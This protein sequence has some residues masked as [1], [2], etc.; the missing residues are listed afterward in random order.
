[1]P[2]IASERHLSQKVLY[3]KCRRAIES[4][5]LVWY[6]FVN[7]LRGFGNWCHLHVWNMLWQ[8]L[9]WKSCPSWTLSRK[10]LNHHQSQWRDPE[11]E[12]LSNRQGNHWHYVLVVEVIGTH[13]GL[14]RGNLLL[15]CIMELCLVL[16]RMLHFI[17]LRYLFYEHPYQRV[18]SWQSGFIDPPI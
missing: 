13:I 17:F 1:M 5:C 15:G 8:V 10:A 4:A 14:L 3:V 11:Q 9:K 18:T 12:V 16:S 2:E 6:W 7:G